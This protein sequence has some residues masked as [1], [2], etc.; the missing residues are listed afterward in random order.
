MS[1]APP[2]AS[3]AS[4]ETDWTDQVADLIVDVVD[5]I[6]DRTTGPLIQA[7][8]WLVYG[9]VALFIGMVLVVLGIILIGR[10]LGLLPLDIWI[11]YSVIGALFTFGGLVLWGRRGTETA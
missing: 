2:P 5:R 7:S 11:P 10:L 6:H 9:T 8:R 3:P 1:A 4:E